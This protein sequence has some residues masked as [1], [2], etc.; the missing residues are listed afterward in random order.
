MNI[1]IINLELHVIIIVAHLTYGQSYSA[2]RSSIIGKCKPWSRS[3]VSP[4]IQYVSANVQIDQPNHAFVE[5]TVKHPP[6]FD[7]FKAWYPLVPVEILD[8]EKPHKYHLLGQ[9]IVVWYDGPVEGGGNW[10]TKTKRPKGAKRSDQGMWRAFVDECPHRKVPLSEGRVEDDGTLLCS[11]HAWKFDGS[12]KCISVPQVES[13]D[14][15]IRIKN[16]PKSNCNAFPT[17]VINGLLFVWPSTDENAI[18]ESE[19][20]PVV[21][22]AEEADKERLFE[23]PWNFR[24]LPYGADYFIENVVDPGRIEYEKK[25]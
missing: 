20:T 2:K 14:E 19:L 15:L 1:N 6:V 16:N 18:L 10:G 8:R 17:K 5:E 12:G 4:I 13:S 11:Y 23:G 9:D 22:R 3:A 24:E 21:H 25:R 7:W